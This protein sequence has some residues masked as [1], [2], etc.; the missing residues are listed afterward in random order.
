MDVQFK[1]GRAVGSVRHEAV[2][3]W[4]TAQGFDVNEVPLDA[5]ITI[6]GEQVTA[7]V[8]KRDSK[9]WVLVAKTRALVSEPSDLVMG[10]TAS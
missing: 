8:Y 2:K 4:L 7:D 1:A 3:A 5:T 6:D 9:G 10:V